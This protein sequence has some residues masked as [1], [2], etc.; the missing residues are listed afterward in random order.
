MSVYARSLKAQKYRS[1][2]HPCFPLYARG[3]MASPFSPDFI[4][5]D[6]ALLK[7]YPPRPLAELGPGLYWS[8]AKLAR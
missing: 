3:V 5:H 4:R 1:I 2:A 6:Q 7:H 8:P